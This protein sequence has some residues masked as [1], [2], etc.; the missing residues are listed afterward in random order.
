MAE[1]STLLLEPGNPFDFTD[2]ELEELIA[3]VRNDVPDLKVDVA[4]REEVG[5][6]VTLIEVLHVFVE[7]KEEIS[8]T[9][10]A[11][12]AVIRWM[13]RRWERDKGRQR[14][15]LIWGPRGEPLKSVKIDDPDGE[16]VEEDPPQENRPRPR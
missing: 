15:V 4:V 7:H 16:P 13:K 11:V 3:A 5:Y 8:L 14:A 10:G 12:G 2:Q 1:S 6:G 9:A